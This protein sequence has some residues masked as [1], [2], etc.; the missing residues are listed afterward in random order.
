VLLVDLA[1]RAGECVDCGYI[2][3]I[4]VQPNGGNELLVGG[5]ELCNCDYGGAP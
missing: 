2:T 4:E 3:V 5:F 1:R